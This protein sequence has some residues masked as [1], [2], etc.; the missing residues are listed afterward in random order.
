MLGVDGVLGVG[1]LAPGS[2]GL[3][4]SDGV[5]V[6]GAGVKLLGAPGSDG[7]TVPGW[8]VLLGAPG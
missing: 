2:V 4:G 7:A 3:P 6:P 1:E 8:V 5:T